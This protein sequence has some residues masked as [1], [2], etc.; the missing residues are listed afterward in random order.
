MGGRRVDHGYSWIVALSSTWMS[1]LMI[2]LYTNYGLLFVEL[3]EHFTISK[4]ALGWLMAVPYM[5][6]FFEGLFIPKIVTRFG[7]RKVGLV[8][9]VI[10]LFG[11][12]L[13]AFTPS[14]YLLYFSY[15]ICLAGPLFAFDLLNWIILQ[16]NF[17]KRRTTA[18][19]IY[20]CGYS[21][22]AFLWPP[23]YR[24]FL[25]EYSWRGAFLMQ[26]A[27]QFHIAICVLLQTHNPI[28]HNIGTKLQESKA[29]LDQELEVF[30]NGTTTKQ[31]Q[32]AK[33]MQTVPQQKEERSTFTF[34]EILFL[35]ALFLFYCGDSFGELM[36][37]VRLAYVGLSK[38][39]I[40]IVLSAGGITGII[41]VLPAWIIDKLKINKL[42]TSAVFA[43]CLGVLMLISILFTNFGTMLFYFV[44]F[45][46]FQCKLPRIERE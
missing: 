13:S 22:G 14:V 9:V 44:M 24:I 29:E 31:I 43:F 20:C 21:I 25:D 33:E 26:G 6:A 39:Q 4:F 12:I 45:A 7:H 36:T 2:G 34:K 5:V 40:T 35:C 17:V 23:L 10:N 28:T 30:E 37:A 3:L 32:D 1:S 41:R 11:H 19:A 38:K 27:V 8:C 18:S 42:V 16:D 46:F 15:S